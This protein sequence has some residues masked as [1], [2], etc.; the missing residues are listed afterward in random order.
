[1]EPYFEIK[2][3]HAKSELHKTPI[4]DLLSG[5]GVVAWDST[6]CCHQP[7]CVFGSTEILEHY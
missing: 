4:Q 2:C 7:W 3:L 6:Y 1:L 5:M